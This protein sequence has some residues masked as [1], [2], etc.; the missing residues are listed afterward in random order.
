MKN[1][2]KNSPSLRS[3]HVVREHQNLTRTQILQILQISDL[4]KKDAVK[5]FNNYLIALNNDKDEDRG[6]HD[7]LIA[8]DDPSYKAVK[9][10]TKETSI[11]ID[12]LTKENEALKK[13]NDETEGSKGEEVNDALRRKVLDTVREKEGQLEGARER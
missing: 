4:Q 12:A 9:K 8:L 6:I 2:K 7:C 1:V 10:L 11:K 3:I 5:D 13:V